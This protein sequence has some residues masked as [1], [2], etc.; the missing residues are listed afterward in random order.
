MD[1]TPILCRRLCEQ[2]SPFKAL[3]VR[4]IEWA[5]IRKQVDR[6]PKQTV[7]TVQHDAGENAKTHKA[8]TNMERNHSNFSEGGEREL[9]SSL[10]SDTNIPK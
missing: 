2:E 6:Q 3:W 5:F 4:K 10:R 1:A 8:R 7:S 9:R